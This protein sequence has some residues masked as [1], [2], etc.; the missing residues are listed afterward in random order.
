MINSKILPR[1]YVKET[2]N[3]PIKI[4]EIERFISNKYC[5]MQKT[6]H[7]LPELKNDIDQICEYWFSLGFISEVFKNDLNIFLQGNFKL[8]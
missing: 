3:Y 2:N 4:S 5:H 7:T 8:Q 6:E 1:M